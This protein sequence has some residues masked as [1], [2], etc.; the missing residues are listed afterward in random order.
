LYSISYYSSMADLFSH[1]D[2]HVQPKPLND[3]VFARSTS[4]PKPKPK[5][6][7]FFAGSGLVTQGMQPHFECIWANDISEKKAAVYR[8]NHGN[9]HFALG[10][11][12]NV[13]GAN[14]PD[15]DLAWASFPCQDLSLA[16]ATA[17]IYASRSGLVWEWLRVVDEMPARPRILVAENVAGLVTSSTGANYR[18]LHTA[19]V[20]RGYMVGAIFLDA[21][22][23]LPQSRT[24]V[25]V[26]A[27]DSET[28]IPSDLTSQS[29]CWLHTESLR[30]ACDGLDGLIW[31][32]APP[33]QI[34]RKRLSE[35]IDWSAP[36]A[37]EDFEK[38][39]ISLIA[40]KHKAVLDSLPKTTRYAAPGY[41]RTRNGTQTLELRFDD[42][43][44]CLRTP[45]G[46]SSR[47]LL[48]LRDQSDW[49]CR[50]ITAREAARLMGAPDNYVL[51]TSYNDA[52]KAMG[53]AVAV[54]A[55]EWL[56]KSI[57]L[58]LAG[59]VGE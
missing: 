17:G 6:L 45:E 52:Y 15:A 29:P 41:R 14:L 3:H 25:F 34:S 31:W 57:L 50:L 4:E 59:E 36:Y 42:T 11:I 56:A 54:P 28:L 7:D 38:H 35:I 47:Q 32:N 43:A 21:A 5:F 53:D 1:P 58:P 8:A 51:P 23:W 13:S 55:V 39:N 49:R 10:S 20:E 18:L 30:R 2:H 44:G 9:E 46:G 33:P 48:V 19:L 22:L 16:G 26:I 37:K 24:R 40:P 27:V 12:T